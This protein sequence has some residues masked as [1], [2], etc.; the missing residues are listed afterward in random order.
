MRA[1]LTLCLLAGC[2]TTVLADDPYLPWGDDNNATLVRQG[3]HIEWQRSAEIGAN[4]ELIIS[5]SDTRFGMRD[6]FAQKLDASQ[7]GSPAVWETDDA[8]HGLVDALIVN[9]DVIR[10]EDPVLI[11]DAAGGAIISW[12]D[13]R[14]DAAGDLYVNRLIDDGGSGGL[15]W[16]EDGVQICDECANGTENMSKSMCID[17]TGGAYVVWGDNRGNNWDLYITRIAADG[18]IDPDFGFNGLGICTEVGDQRVVTM[19]HDGNGGAYVAWLDGREAS[20]DN[21]YI[22]HVHP[23][24]T[25]SAGGNGQ[26]VVG[27][28]GRQYSPK[29]TWDGDD[30]C[31]IAW[32]DQR[33]DNA[34]DIYVQHYSSDLTPT[35]AADGVAMADEP[36]KDENNPRVSYAGDGHTLLMFESNVNDPGNTLAD[37]FVQKMNTTD[38][39][40]WGEYGVTACD[41]PGNQEQARVTGDG[42]GGAFL[43]WQD[44]MTETYAHIRAQKLNSS[45]GL[46]WGAQ[47]AVVVDHSDTESDAIQ[48]ALREDQD[49][50]LFVAWGDLSRGSLGVFTQ[51]LD[52]NGQVSFESAG[53]ASAWGISGSVSR[54]KNVATDEGTMVFWV[55]PRNADGPHVYMQFLD[56]MTGE[57][58]HASNGLPVD[59]SLSG[60]QHKYDVVPD[61]SGGAFVAIEA[62][63]DG[64]QQGF[65][66]RINS[67]G[68][69]VWGESMPVTP[70]FDPENSGLY[71]MQNLK[72]ERSADQVVLA[73]SGVDTTY[74]L[75]FAEVS[76]QAFDF[77]GNALWGDQ[78]V[79]LTETATIHETFNDLASDGQGGVYAVWESGDWQDTDVLIQHVDASGNIAYDAGG[80]P[81][82]AG[83]G[84]IQRKAS[85]VPRMGGGVIGIWEDLTADASNSD[86]IARA[87]N[88]SG[89]ELWRT[90][91]DMRA[92]SQKTAVIVNDRYDGIYVVY[93]DFSNNDN[94]DVYQRHV[95]SDGSLVWDDASG[96]L[97]VDDGTQEDVAGVMVPMVGWSGFVVAL[98]AE[99]TEDTTGYKDLWVQQNNVNQA[100]GVIDG[101][102]YDGNVLEFFHNQREPF[103]SHDG[104]GGVY[105]SWIDMR[106]SGKED[107]K[108]VYTT[109][110]TPQPTS[111]VAET[112]PAAFTLRQNYPN[113]FNPET[114]IEYQLL[115]PGQVELAVYNLAG[116]RVRTLVDE[117]QASGTYRMSF[118]G[119][120]EQGLGLS[121]GIYFYRLS[122]AD[123]FSAE[124]RMLLIK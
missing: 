18:T 77:S 111:S 25:L 75:F 39:Q 63:S 51:H 15:A 59:L 78:G 91:V 50:G 1:S 83:A 120:N 88:A 81:F 43:V 122:T 72:L 104:M 4:G 27:A 106:A 14:S 82:G 64:A 13:F 123:G 54:V 9:D 53:D 110:V 66:T 90:E 57:P 44:Y 62:G 70:A 40:V 45:G 124:K 68:E 56:D 35:F 76:A 112:R 22:E 26:L 33:S 121:S 87:I 94:D 5:W 48:P 96:S 17:G 21:I 93:T 16:G 89:S 97:F 61:G 6:L 41:N 32:V 24:G 52:S 113:P 7:S 3:Y 98:A 86:L 95:L 46:L 34:G 28:S 8:T 19:E 65:L 85:I 47:G 20:D 37:I 107:I 55:D 2:V 80:V 58:A 23:D 74:S 108:D 71:Y 109:R 38:L 12:V 117:S 101:I 103:L 99:E 29:V 30:G 100:S 73:W 36:G 114:V 92:G 116:Q 11:T 49:G 115:R 10:Q 102:E 79:R 119:R 42:N 60:G 67:Q 118:D 69:M 31:W 105:M 84:G